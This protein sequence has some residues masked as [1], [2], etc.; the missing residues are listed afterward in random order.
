[1]PVATLWFTNEKCLVT[2]ETIIF[3]EQFCDDSKFSASVVSLPAL[4]S[5]K[6]DYW[7]ARYIAWVIEVGRFFPNQNVNGTS[8]DPQTTFN[9]WWMTLPT[10]SSFES[11]SLAYTIMRLWALDQTVSALEIQQ[12]N[13]HNATT[14]IS[15]LLLEWGNSRGIRIQLLQNSRRQGANM[16]IRELL[17]SSNS[18]M[19]RATQ[20]TAV[21]VA[22]M[23]FNRGWLES[24][25]I[26]TGTPLDADFVIF[27]Y[28]A[29]LEIDESLSTKFKSRYWGD[30]PELLAQMN[31]SVHWV[32]IF[33]PTASARRMTDAV[34]QI[35]KLN[36]NSVNQSH[37][38]L[39]SYTNLT[40]A[41]RSFLTFR[42]INKISRRLR[43]SIT[44][45]MRDSSQPF[46][47]RYVWQ[48]F[49]S[50][51]LGSG[52]GENALVISLL[53]EYISHCSQ[54]S[55]CM[56]LMENQPW[57]M[58]LLSIWGRSPR[59][60]VIGVTHSTTRFWDLRY[61]LTSMAT[62]GALSSVPQPDAVLVNGV[63]SARQL[64]IN[65]VDPAR[66]RQVEALRYN[67][68]L[69]LRRPEK[70]NGKS[71]SRP[72]L[73]VFGE[74]AESMSR[75]Q[76]DL[77]DSLIKTESL[78]WDIVYRP[79]PAIPPTI[80]DLNSDIRLDYESSV[81]DLLSKSQASLCGSVSSAVFDS[82]IAY[83][84]VIILRDASFLDGNFIE[85]PMVYGIDSLS[86]L[87]E[88]LA[89]I[90]ENMVRSQA[91]DFHDLEFFNLDT[92]LDLWRNL[93]GEFKKNEN[94]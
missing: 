60:G 42:R 16:N 41:M 18:S 46:L 93:L 80:S 54:R 70:K 34:S 37:T 2:D 68:L 50:S 66:I 39:Q 13:V 30:L 36:Q 29:N 22:N 19:L 72:Q 4:V 69:G 25:S 71:T 8:D 1:V 77:L 76:L 5:D 6:R 11:S 58:A 7:R 61:A 65:G 62:G 81:S 64:I 33:I 59:G 53:D 55:T 9:Y 94:I 74:Y 35:E 51:T 52:A 73:L 48:N 23:F 90:S 78:D 75:R 56:Y 91:T 67:G 3:W 57:E 32:H 45:Y 49:Q 63:Q 27:D 79:H 87:K 83:T 21:L 28:F 86:S 44:R 17:R 82:L 43:K 15:A 89:M 92:S 40:V 38:I 10:Q 12:L 88:A 85:N 84:P 31:F 14:E 20:G 47:S 24:R 26:K